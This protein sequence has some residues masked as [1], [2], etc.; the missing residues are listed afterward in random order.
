MQKN[1]LANKKESILHRQNKLKLKDTNLF[2]LY[3]LYLE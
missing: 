3:I 2:V 1:E